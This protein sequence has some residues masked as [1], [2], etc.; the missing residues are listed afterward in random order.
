MLRFHHF[1]VGGMWRTEYGDP[2]DPEDFK[3]L[4]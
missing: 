4:T 1:T 2:D 3:V